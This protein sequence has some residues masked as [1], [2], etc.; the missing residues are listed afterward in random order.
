MSSRQES[1][2]R[3]SERTVV[4]VATVLAAFAQ[5][6]SSQ[7]CVHGASPIFEVKTLGQNNPEPGALNTITMSLKASVKLPASSSIVI[8]GLRGAAQVLHQGSVPGVMWLG[9]AYRGRPELFCAF[10]MSSEQKPQWLQSSNGAWDEQGHVLTLYV[11]PGAEIA[12]EEVRFSITVQNPA[13]PQAAPEISI[14]ARDASGG[15]IVPKMSMSRPQGRMIL[16]G[17]P[18]GLQALHVEAATIPERVVLLSPAGGHGLASLAASLSGVVEIWLRPGWYQETNCNAFWTQNFTMRGM[19]SSSEDTVVDCKGVH[20]HMEIRGASGAG[21]IS[22]VMMANGFAQ[23]DGGCI[24]VQGGSLHLQDVSF[25]NCRAAGPALQGPGPSGP[26]SSQW[27]VGSGFGGAVAVISS[28]CVDNM[29]WRDSEGLGC[30]SYNPFPKSLIRPNFDDPSQDEAARRCTSAAQYANKGSDARSECC[31]CKYL[32]E[33]SEGVCQDDN[34]GVSTDSG[35][36]FKDCS[37]LA[38]FCADDSGLVAQYGAPEGWL[39][40]RCPKTCGLCADSQ[41]E[42]MDS[43]AQVKSDTSGAIPDC[44]SASG[45]CADDS[46]LVAQGVPEGWLHERCPKTCGLCADP[47]QSNSTSGRVLYMQRVKI[48]SC[49]ASMGGGGVAVWSEGPDTRD[50]RSIARISL[51]HT[52]ISNCSASLGGGGILVLSTVNGMI[53][54][55][56]VV[57]TAVSNCVAA[58]DPRSDVVAFGGGIGIF[59]LWDGT[60]AGID[61]SGIRVDNCNATTGAGGVIIWADKAAKVGDVTMSECRIQSC[62]GLSAGGLVV[63]S[64]RQG[65]FTA[66]VTLQGV[67]VADSH[68]LD[69]PWF[70]GEFEPAIFQGME[71][72]ALFPHAGGIYLSADALGDIRLFN[73]KIMRCTALSIDGWGGG[74]FIGHLTHWIP[75]RVIVDGIV[76]EDC[77]SWLGGAL[78]LLNVG[79]AQPAS[80]V[81]AVLRNNNASLAGGLAVWL[82][83]FTIGPNVTIVGNTVICG[84]GGIAMYGS[85]VKMGASSND[86]RVVIRDNRALGDLDI[87]R[88]DWIK[89]IPQILASKST[90]VFFAGQGGGILVLSTTDLN[91]PGLHWK[92]HLKIL[93]GVS[94]MDNVAGNGGGVALAT[95]M[96]VYEHSPKS[97]MIASGDV[98]IAGNTAVRDEFRMNHKVVLSSFKIAGGEAGVPFG[99]GGGVWALDSSTVSLMDGVV[100][101]GNHA[102]N[103]GGGACVHLSASM[104]MNGAMFVGN[105]AVGDGGAVSVLLGVVGFHRASSVVAQRA[106]FSHN[107]AGGSGGAIATDFDSAVTL[108]DCVLE[109]NSASSGG[110]LASMVDSSISLMACHVSSNQA[111]KDGGGVLAAGFS[112]V[113]VMGGSIDGNLVKTD[114]GGVVAIDSASMTFSGAQRIIVRNNTAVKDGGGMLFS[115][116]GKVRLESKMIY[117]TENAATRGGAICFVSKVELLPGAA[118]TIESN[119]ASEMGGGLFGYGPNADMVISDQHFLNVSSNIAGTNGGGIALSSLAKMG[120]VPTTSCPCKPSSLGDGVCNLDCMLLECNWDMGDCHNIFLDAGKSASLKC[121]RSVCSHVEEQMESCFSPCMTAQCDWS[122][123]FCQSQ[124]ALLGKCPLFDAVVLESLETWATGVKYVEEGSVNSYGRCTEHSCSDSAVSTVPYD[125]YAKVTFHIAEKACESKGT[126][127]IMS[128]FDRIKTIGWT[129]VGA[130]GTTNNMGGTFAFLNGSELSVEDPAWLPDEMAIEAG[131]PDGSAVCVAYWRDPGPA[132]P[133]SINANGLWAGRCSHDQYE[134]WKNDIQCEDGQ[135]VDAATLE[136]P[137]GKKCVVIDD[138]GQL[139]GALATPGKP[140]RAAWGYCTSKKR[141]PSSGFDHSEDILKDVLRKNISTLLRLFPGCGGRPLEVAKNIAGSWGGGMYLSDCDKSAERSGIC[142]L[143]N[144]HAKRLSAMQVNFNGNHAGL[145]GGGIFIKCPKISTICDAVIRAKINLPKIQGRIIVVDGNSADGYGR[146]IAQA[147]AR[148][149]TKNVLHEYAP[150][151]D[152]SILRLSVAVFDEHGA[153]VRGSENIANPYQV[154]LEICPPEWISGTSSSP[155]L[156]PRREVC[157]AKEQL[158]PKMTFRL[159][160]TKG[161]TNVHPF[162]FSLKRCL[163]GMSH[164]SVHLSLD[165]ESSSDVSALH[166]SFLVLCLPCG[167]GEMYTES[168]DELGRLLWRCQQCDDSQYTHQDV[169]FGAAQHITDSNAVDVRCQRCPIG[170]VCNG[171][172]I[173]GKVNGSEWVRNGSHVRLQSCPKGYILVRN[174]DRPETDE[175]VLCPRGKYSTQPSFYPR[176]GTPGARYVT[177]SSLALSFCIECNWIKSTCAGGSDVTPKAGFWYPAAH[178]NSTNSRRQATESLNESLQVELIA[179]NPAERCLRG[180]VCAAG[181]HGPVCG[182]CKDGFAMGSKD[183]CIACPKSKRLTMQIVGVTVLVGL[184][185]VAYYFILLQPLLRA[186][187]DQVDKPQSISPLWHYLGRKISVIAEIM[188]L[189]AFMELSVMKVVARFFSAVFERIH[190]F[191]VFCAASFLKN[192][193]SEMVKV[194]ISFMQVSGS[195]L[196]GYPI[197]WPG[198]LENFLRFALAFTVRLRSLPGNLACAMVGMTFY[199][200]Q[201]CYLIAPLVLIALL[202]L[203]AIYVKICGRTHPQYG[204]VIKTFTSTFT[205]VLFLLYPILSSP[206]LDVFHCVDVGGGKRRLKGDLELACPANHPSSRAFIL[207]I[208][209]VLLYPVG[210][211]LLFLSLILYYQVPQMAK[212]KIEDAYAHSLIAFYKK[213]QAKTLVAKIAMEVGGSASLSAID[214]TNELASPDSVADAHNQHPDTNQAVAESQFKARIKLLFDSATNDGNIQLDAARLRHYLHQLG[215][216]GAQETQLDQ[217]FNAYDD[218]GNGTLDFSEFQAMIR[219]ITEHVHLF[220]GTE[221]L[222]DLTIAQLRTLVTFNWEQVTT[223]FDDETGLMLTVKKFVLEKENQIAKKRNLKSLKK[224]ETVNSS[225]S[226][227]TVSA[228]FFQRTSSDRSGPTSVRLA[229]LHTSQGETYEAPDA[230]TAPLF[231]PPPIDLDDVHAMRG[232]VVSKGTEMVDHGSIALPTVGWDGSTASEKHALDRISFIFSAYKVQFFYY[233]LLEMIRKLLM[234]GCMGLVMPGLPQQFAIGLLIT[235]S[236][237]VLSLRLQPWAH[238]SLNTLNL[239]SL[240]FQTIILFTGLVKS[241]AEVTV[242]TARIS[243]KAVTQKLIVALTVMVATVP[244][245]ILC[246]E[247][248]INPFKSFLNRCG[249]QHC[250]TASTSP[251]FSNNQE[252]CG[253]APATTDVNNAENA[254]MLPQMTAEP[255]ELPARPRAIDSHFS[256]VSPVEQLASFSPSRERHIS[257]GLG[258]RAIDWS[259]SPAPSILPAIT[260]ESE[261]VDGG[262]FFSLTS[263]MIPVRVRDDIEKAKTRLAS[264][265]ISAIDSPALSAQSFD[266]HGSAGDHRHD[267]LEKGGSRSSLQLKRGTGAALSANGAVELIRLPLGNMPDNRVYQEPRLLAGAAERS[268]TCAARDIQLAT[269]LMHSPLSSPLPRVAAVAD[270]DLS[271]AEVGMQPGPRAQ[272]C[273]HVW[274]HGLMRIFTHRFRSRG[275]WGRRCEVFERSSKRP[276][277]RRFEGMESLI[278]RAR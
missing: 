217:L 111:R 70:L 240:S 215:I 155:V 207:G 12:C 265:M 38:F 107:T 245:A 197:K 96:P 125:D 84:G 2:R 63:G 136:R 170:A 132:H 151:R 267:Q 191:M 72:N 80:V 156:A 124:K 6:I 157:N 40:E 158:Q 252:D 94:I 33:L 102:E 69:T 95:A 277:R 232:W 168:K 48:S 30:E 194:I 192:N 164:M 247:N 129:W 198:D 62:N 187:D 183:L 42:C 61:L 130:K 23:G 143:L 113:K 88:S 25:E 199:Q 83:D 138:D 22:N 212:A 116:D 123:S 28:E 264:D 243:D 218:D 251:H 86:L 201:L 77:A 31:F 68:A 47:P 272:A 43:D 181:M 153:L 78:F 179:C 253:S 118:T 171:K 163:V 241:I 222:H 90:R 144:S 188:R 210:I 262:R 14:E 109:Q 176:E 165:D 161:W 269:P 59:S 149:S 17:V 147:P 160:A 236:F 141:L 56:H 20:R 274:M 1:F 75:S 140:Q 258:H 177:D 237:L 231:L 24:L 200:L 53:G 174:E 27:R 92:A 202:S 209:L 224:A 57:D 220:S 172:M 195:F 18:L 58:A 255:A 52:L 275:S 266:I 246:V 79:H 85:S 211:L 196:S 259:T 256:H 206:A 203:P 152:K 104:V 162:G 106:K 93:G 242:D 114:G 41:T 66:S 146:E 36:A 39:H 101:R 73:T 4:A 221:R 7:P 122:K 71:A 35:G 229:S 208:I 9:G 276:R 180:G 121:D 278:V 273:L 154:S 233:E 134:S 110:G 142:P 270:G 120:I 67:I 34:I 37:E 5:V 185:C 150:G 190:D 54:S 145:A 271:E 100:V 234:V 98:L 223:K 11:C 178:M 261:T 213:S 97:V 204:Q 159:E 214:F 133:G 216:S 117:M 103:T 254:D 13:L 29:E 105:N 205:F 87:S 128:N 32:S 64:R 16:S 89:K 65:E 10:P 175:C 91:N 239:F 45:F 167:P 228:S 44:A 99:D 76:V 169:T 263:D 50:H 182:V 119:R 235:V 49:T 238:P 173:R 108:Q 112:K 260:S 127:L 51:S 166:S 82:C 193:G 60:V 268:V 115:T 227:S 21:R 135:V 19:S 230:A 126:T 186:D 219:E 26:G 148:L 8:S 81:N 249:C 248:K 257:Q 15:S 184:F 131:L 225:Q 137:E 55:V 74:I 139:A 46:V 244:A 250:G 3:S 226:V 189:E